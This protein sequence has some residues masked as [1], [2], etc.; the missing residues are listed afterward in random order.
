MASVVASLAIIPTSPLAPTTFSTPSGRTRTTSR[1]WCGGTVSSSCRQR[2][3][4]RTSSQAAGISETYLE[5]LFNEGPPEDG[6]SNIAGQPSTVRLA[7]L[8]AVPRT[9]APTLTTGMAT[10][11]GFVTIFGDGGQSGISAFN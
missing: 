8:W 10:V 11:A 6:P 4:S 9:T 5:E 3:T 2:F 7:T 1:T